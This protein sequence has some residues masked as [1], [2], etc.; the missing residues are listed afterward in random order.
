[1]ATFTDSARLLAMLAQD[2]HGRVRRAASHRLLSLM[3]A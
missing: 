2:N 3:V 1:L